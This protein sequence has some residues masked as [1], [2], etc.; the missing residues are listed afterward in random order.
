MSIALE[1]AEATSA[2]AAKILELYRIAGIDDG[3]QLSE[4]QAQAMLERVA[5]YPNYTFYLVKQQDNVVAT[6]ALL[7]MDNLGHMGTPSAILEGVA[8]SADFQGRGIGKAMMEFVLQQCAEA[9]CYKLTLSSN[10]KREQA[11][12][13]YDNLGFDRHGYSYSI[14]I[15]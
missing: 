10:I 4:Q 2:D 1:Y 14:N 15:G 9:G 7:I 13:F 11:H 12:Q 5:S 3:P 6:F 8:V